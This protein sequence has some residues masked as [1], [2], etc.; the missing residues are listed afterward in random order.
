MLIRTVQRQK[1]KSCCGNCSSGKPCC[2]TIKP[3]PAFEK[4]RGLWLPRRDLTLPKNLLHYPSEAEWSGLWRPWSPALA[5]VFDLSCM[6]CC[7]DPC[8]CRSELCTEG[9]PLSC[10]DLEV[11]I[12]NAS[13][14][15]G[16]GCFNAPVVVGPLVFD[17]TTTWKIEGVVIGCGE[18]VS[19]FLSCAIGTTCEWS[20]IINCA[21]V[22]FAGDPGV[23]NSCDPL[24]I[25]FTDLCGVG[26]VCCPD[27][28]AV[29]PACLDAV[30]SLA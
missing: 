9:P 26:S 21:G 23:Q 1:R 27:A 10:V 29:T 25:S 18:T 4:R 19:V 24:S 13:L 20:L 15:D 11:T 22:A 17:G 30:V 12:S 3:K 5:T 6:P 14:C 28:G 16:T 2:G 7:G 8:C